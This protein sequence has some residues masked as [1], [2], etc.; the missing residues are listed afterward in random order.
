M[1]RSR[2][3]SRSE[4]TS[5]ISVLASIWLVAIALTGYCAPDLRSWAHASAALEDSDLVAITDDVQAFGDA[6]GL[7]DVHDQL[8]RLRERIHKGRDTA[9]PP[10]LP[11]T[12]RAAPSPSA[13]SAPSRPADANSTAN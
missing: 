5:P 2:S 8:E 3:T 9:A 12:A 1:S 4:P 13:P 11:P 7:A 10:P 6:T